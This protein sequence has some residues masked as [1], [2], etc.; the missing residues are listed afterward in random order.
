[1]KKFQEC[2]INYPTS[3]V[4]EPPINCDSLT[5]GQTYQENIENLSYLIA[6]HVITGLKLTDITDDNICSFQLE[7]DVYEYDIDTTDADPYKKYM[8]KKSF[9]YIFIGY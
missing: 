6:H 9:N 7:Y 4:L 5:V 3:T 8:N 1:M 2:G